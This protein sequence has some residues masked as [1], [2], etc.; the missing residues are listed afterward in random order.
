M[1]KLNAILCGKQIS[2]KKIKTAFEKRFSGG[3]DVTKWTRGDKF[4]EYPILIRQGDFLSCDP[5]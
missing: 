5:W 3:T 2:N 4:W 1:E